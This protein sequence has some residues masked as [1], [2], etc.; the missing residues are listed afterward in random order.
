VRVHTPLGWIEVRR[1][2]IDVG[3]GR[4][5]EVGLR[6]IEEGGGLVA[7]LEQGEGVGL[8]E[9]AIHVSDREDGRR[10]G[11]RT[12][13]WPSQVKFEGGGREEG[14]KASVSIG[15]IDV[16]EMQRTMESLEV[17]V[18]VG[19]RK[20]LVGKARVFPF[21]ENL[22]SGFTARTERRQRMTR[23]E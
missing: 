7:V 8:L 15:S 4:V 17:V 16:E 18:R 11:P 3:R 6:R 2:R 13:N 22:I 5:V 19:A 14:E 10:K 21:D 1:G 12:R 23:R 9:R 20:N